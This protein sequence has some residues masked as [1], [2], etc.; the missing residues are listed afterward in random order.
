MYGFVRERRRD[1]EATT[2]IG[3]KDAAVEELMWEEVGERMESDEE[4]E[5]GEASEDGAHAPPAPL[6]LTSEHE[7][8]EEQEMAERLR[9]EVR[10][11]LERVETKAA[12]AIQAA[13]RGLLARRRVHQERAKKKRKAASAAAAAAAAVAEAAALIIPPEKRR[14]QGGDALNYKS[15]ASTGT[16]SRA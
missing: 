6:V 15:L 16:Y 11:D 13:Y 9:V 10:A 4:E 1:I 7:S 2:S 5:E 14:R 12:I 8:M 3:A